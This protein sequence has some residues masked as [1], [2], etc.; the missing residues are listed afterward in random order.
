MKEKV[1]DT[2]TAVKEG[3]MKAKEKLIGKGKSQTEVVG[4]ISN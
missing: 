2:W 3:A 1:H 4:K